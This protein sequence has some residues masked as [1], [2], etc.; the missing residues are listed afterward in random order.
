LVLSGEQ[1]LS[2]DEPLRSIQAEL[3]RVESL[4][5]ILDASFFVGFA[6][7][8]VSWNTASVVVVP[9]E[10]KYTEMANLEAK[11]LSE[12]VMERSD[13]FKFRM[14]LLSI[15]ET[16]ERLQRNGDRQLFVADSGDNTT[17]GAH[18]ANTILLD[19]LVAN[20]PPQKKICVST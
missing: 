15:E 18:G 9:E 20:P 2:S 19:K 3:D 7:A 5:G 16:V 11:R 12:Y 8:D 13:D 14:P 6:W 1:A 17:G 4:P 10:A